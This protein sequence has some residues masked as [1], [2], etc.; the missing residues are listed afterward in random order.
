MLFLLFRDMAES[1]RRGSGWAERGIPA[2]WN[3]LHALAYVA[4]GKNGDVRRD[5]I[6]PAS[7]ALATAWLAAIAC[8]IGRAR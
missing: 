4:V 8:R 2:I 7:R 1:V 5:V 3:L 6:V